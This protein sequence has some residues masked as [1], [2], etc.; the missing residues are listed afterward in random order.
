MNVAEL[1][2]TIVR[3]LPG[4]AALDVIATRV[5]T[6]LRIVGE[7]VPPGD[8]LIAGGS[9]ARGEPTF[10]RQEG[11][12]QLASDV[13]LL[14]VHS[15]EQ[16]L[17]SIT[18][19]VAT[20]QKHFPNVDL[21]T[22]SLREYRLLRTSL[23]HDF[24]NLGLPISGDG[25]PSHDRVVLEARDA[26]E[27]LL[28]YTQAYFW[29]GLHEQ[30]LSG[31]DAPSFHHTIS[32]LCAKV[33]RATAM[34]D[35][36]YA[37]HDFDS[38]PPHIAQSMRAELRWRSNPSRRGMPPGR[39]WTYM[40]AALRRFDEEFGHPRVDAISHSRYATTSSG[41]I[42]AR[43]HRAAHHLARAMSGTW[44]DTADP[45]VLTT[46]KHRAWSGYTDCSGTCPQIGPEQYFRLHQREIHDHLLAMKVQVE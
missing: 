6:S 33:L 31:A 16:P 18:D 38:M 42:V 11:S 14:Y 41:R 9:L 39:F 4:A 10:V 30:W 36:A 44:L 19:L 34:L 20:A 37:H 21:M 12:W 27:I 13:D 3:R 1:S 5:A 8:W 22:L 29:S 15:G 26:Y 25:L 32:R 24:K 2:R 7:C 28:Y 43:H 17:V 23:G 40:A 45:Q 35:G 46:V